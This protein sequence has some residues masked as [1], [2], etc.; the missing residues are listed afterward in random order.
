MNQVITDPEAQEAYKRF[1]AE[2]KNRTLVEAYLAV[3]DC[4]TQKDFC[5]RLN[6]SESQFSRLLAKVEKELSSKDSSPAQTA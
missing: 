3:K 6:L 4:I 1:S 5:K 2:I